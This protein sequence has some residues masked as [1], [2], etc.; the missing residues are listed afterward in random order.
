MVT[1][2]DYY[3]V[4]GVPRT[5]SEDEIRKA[6]RRLA[7]Q[8]HP[9]VNSDPEAE[10]RFKEAN[11]AYE[12]LSNPQRRTSYDQY[13]HRG[14][15]GGINATTFDG[16]GGLGDLFETFFGNATAASRGPQR[17]ADL[18]YDLNLT[19]EEAVFGAKK[20]IEIPRWETC[21][22]CRGTGARPGS[23]PARCSVCGG[24]GEIRRTQQSI[25]G[26]FVNVVVCDRCRGEGRVITDPC[27]EC[28]GSGRVRTV[29]TL[30]VQV[31]AGVDSDTQMRLTGEGEAGQRGGPRGN[32]LIAFHVQPHPLFRRRGSD[33][34]IDVPVSFS[35]VT[36]GDEV[37]VPTVEGTV[38]LR[39]PAGAQSGRRFT[40]K[41]KGIPH[42]EGSGRG[43][44]YVTIHVVTPSDLT[45]RERE[46][47]RELAKLESERTQHTG[48]HWWEKVKEAVTGSA[49]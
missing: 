21:A 30:E 25:F 43:D 4:L 7:R 1:K 31:P 10:E 41:G 39:I 32:L 34:F 44:Q 16:F 11:E 47:F 36:L 33:T 15:P 19:F 29:R 2:R 26:Q 22:Q 18:R 28:R 13:G 9:D 23:T 42:L 3:E 24:S 8:Y 38:H 37:E 20:T 48:K 6:F 17:G 45:P 12:V 14:G 27:P 46:L 35:Q 40:L 5:A 49:E